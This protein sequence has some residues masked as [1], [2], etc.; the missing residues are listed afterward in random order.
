MDS[1]VPR[2]LVIARLLFIGK[3]EVGVMTA[4]ILDE[5]TKEENMSA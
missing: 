2:G 3:S 1:T 5:R 4:E